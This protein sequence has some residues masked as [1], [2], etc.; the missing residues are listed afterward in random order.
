MDPKQAASAAHEAMN[1]AYATVGDVEAKAREY[2][3][4]DE[5]KQA[6]I[7]AIDKEIAAL[8]LI[9]KG[10]VERINAQFSGPMAKT[11]TQ[12]A[13]L[14]ATEAIL[15]LELE[16][17]EMWPNWQE[18]AS[19]AIQRAI[20]KGIIKAAEFTGKVARPVLQGLREGFGALKNAAFGK[21]ID[22]RTQTRF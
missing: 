12:K 16:A 18:G 2:L 17:R 19:V 20:K 21:K 4:L 3:A 11:L 6:R 7:K 13:N 10:K 15:P 8:R 9:E 22:T 1:K 5:A 14:E